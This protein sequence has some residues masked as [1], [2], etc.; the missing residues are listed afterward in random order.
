MLICQT[1][2]SNYTDRE[3]TERLTIFN[4]LLSIIIGRNYIYSSFLINRI[5]FLL[6]WGCQT[7]KGGCIVINVAPVQTETTNK[8]KNFLKEVVDNEKHF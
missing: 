1:Y 2:R 3:Q 7:I 5:I 4:A 8:T 6:K